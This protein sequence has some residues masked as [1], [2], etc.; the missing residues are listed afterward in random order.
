MLF[1]KGRTN[2]NTGKADLLLYVVLH[3]FSKHSAPHCHN[4]CVRITQQLKKYVKQP[5]KLP[6]E[7]LRKLCIFKDFMLFLL[8]NHARHSVIVFSRPTLPG[9]T[10]SQFGSCSGLQVL[11]IRIKRENVHQGKTLQSF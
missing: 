7:S 5:M 6:T 8:I 1:S 4:C 10:L 9:I 3:N 2:L 11:I